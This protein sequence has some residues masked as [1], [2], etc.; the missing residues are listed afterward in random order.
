MRTALQSKRPHR[1]IISRVQ[2]YPAPIGGWNDRDSWAIMK[3]TEAIALENLFPNTSYVEG[4]GGSSSHATGTTGNIKTLATYAKVNGTS[5]MYAYTS[6]GIYDVTSPGAVGASEL[7][8]TDG[9]HIWV[10]FG[11]GTNNYLIAVN[12]VDKP[13]Y[14]NGTS[15]V[16]VDGGTS[17]AL[18]GLTTT[19]IA[20]VFVHKN[21]LWFPEKNTLSAWYLSAG[22]AG[23]ALT[24]FSFDGE[25]PRGGYLVAGA[26]WTRDGGDGM[27]DFAVFVTSEGEVLVY[28][29]TNPASAATWAKIGTF[30]VGKPLGKRC[31]CRYGAD[32][33]VLT[34]NGAFPLS[35]AL[36][37]ASV[38]SKMALSFKIERAFNAASSLYF[39]TF[40]WE[41]LNFPTKS[42]LIV[43]VPQSEDGV[44]EQFVMNTI[45]KAWCKFKGWDAETFG[46]LNRDLYFADGTTVYKAWDGSSDSTADIV[47]YAKT[48]FSYFGSENQLKHFKMIRPMLA[49]NGDLTFSADIDVDFQ[50]NAPSNTVFLDLPAS[51]TWD[52]GLWGSATW[53]GGL[54]IVRE[55]ASPDE[56]VGYCAAGKLRISTST[57]TVQWMAVDYIYEPGGVLG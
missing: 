16:A 12:G 18:T 8:R 46:M 35:T 37:T 36:S 27:D 31:L 25:A 43:N 40:G 23:G 51:S 21:R 2:S 54:T 45:T 24:K 52:S 17:P 49:V 1:Q 48:A 3:P 14:Y 50:D 55:W 13:A 53:G 57:L 22:A 6:S 28:Q 9:K 29:G 7:S 44:H 26:N 34:Q 15:W 47:M 39:S 10:N 11:D 38:D 42:A 4:R 5:E 32:L 19:N 33:V 30:F 41:A 56:Y 20:S